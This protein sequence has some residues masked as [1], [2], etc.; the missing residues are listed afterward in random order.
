MRFHPKRRAST[1]QTPG[2]NI[3]KA[4]ASVANRRKVNRSAG[5]ETNLKISTRA[6]IVP[7]MGVYRPK[8]S[9]IPVASRTTDTIAVAVGGS[10]SRIEPAGPAK[11]APTTSRIKIS[12]S[13]GQPPAKVEY[14]RRNGR[15]SPKPIYFEGFPMKVEPPKESGSAL[16]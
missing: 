13:P 3:A 16:F 14:K 5:A 12:P 15:T 2:P 10:A 6:P 1:D 11:A 7:T 4:A 8:A 9:K